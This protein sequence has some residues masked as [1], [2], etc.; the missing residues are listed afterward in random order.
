MRD[1]SV[2][3]LPCMCG[4][5]PEVIEIDGECPSCKHPYRIDW[6]NGRRKRATIELSSGVVMGPGRLRREGE[7]LP[8]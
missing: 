6:L 2:Y 5:S 3:I 8:S 1:N 4:K 7:R